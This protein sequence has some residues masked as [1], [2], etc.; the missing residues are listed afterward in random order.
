MNKFLAFLLLLNSVIF[1]GCNSSNAESITK[2]EEIQNK[3]VLSDWS[4]A[5]MDKADLKKRNVK[6]PSTVL[7]AL[8]LNGEYGDD[9]WYGKN[10]NEISGER[11]ETGWVYS[12]TF[13]I[14]DFDAEKNQIIDFEGINYR[15]NIWVNGELVVDT[16]ECIGVFSTFS[17]N[18]SEFTKQGKNDLKVEMYAPRAGDFTMGFVDWA[19]APAD[20][21]MGIWRP[22]TIK[23]VAG[24][25]LKYT[26]VDSDLNIESLDEADVKITTELLNH[27]TEAQSGVV[28]GS[29]GDVTFEKYYELGAGEHKKITIDKS[30]AKG[31]HF[32][33]PQ[34]WWPV[35]MGKP[36]LYELKIQNYTN[37]VASDQ[38]DI[39]FGI[40]KFEDYFTEEG[41]RGYRINGKEVLRKGGGWVDDLLL[42][43]TVEYDRAQLEYAVHSGLN[44]VR[45]EGFWG[46]DQ[47]LYSM[48][49]EMGLLTMVGFSCQWEWHEYIG[50]D[51]FEDCDDCVGGAI[52]KEWEINLVADYFNDMNKWF[53]NHAGLFLWTGGSDRLHV[54][55]LEEKYLKILDEENPN[56]LFCGAAKMHT[57]PITGI[58]GVK[59]YGP[60][61]Y[62]PPSYWYT[63]TVRGGAYGFNTE[64]GPG[65]QPPVLA[66]L[67]KMIPTESLWPIDTVYWNFHSGR[68]AFADMSRYTK[69]LEARYGKISSVEEFAYLSQIQSYELMRPMYESFVLNRPQATGVVQWMLNSAWP[70]TFWQFYDYYLNATG[71]LY[72]ARV[73]NQPILAAYN[74]KD[75]AVY[76][77]NESYAIQ[78]DLT[79]KLRVLDV[80]SNIVSEQEISL[81]VIENELKKI[82][83]PLESDKVQALLFY[84]LTVLNEE[85]KVVSENFYWISSKED[86]MDPVYDNSNWIYT[87]TVQDADLTGLRSLPATEVSL[88]IKTSS[89]GATVTVKNE[90]DKLAFGIELLPYEAGTENLI[91]PI[92]ISDNYFSLVPGEEKIISLDWNVQT[93]K[94]ELD[95]RFNSLNAELKQ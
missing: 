30:D 62:V 24:V 19:P 34:I 26:F 6:V 94:K 80:Q 18:I 59:M 3:I 61:D 66:S 81:T 60:Y 33:D 45:F 38:E 29:I 14:P 78:K 9:I 39:T 55:S 51:D 11:F 47:E 17:Y 73:A 8:V 5:S 82:F 91:A 58:T 52:D 46:K 41:H 37:G 42:N 15:A 7:G 16:T 57:S 2:V 85:G 95:L 31:L 43:N 53:R 65:P 90:G 88:A 74:Y 71:A 25:E 72:G 1:W 50:V 93:A 54:P 12:T 87:P 86:L 49:D 89:D 35:N 84:D 67:K 36:N 27:T 92:L 83:E 70:E 10:L 76:L 22:V 21:N 69:P 63:D 77:A 40:R 68:H 4:L 13:E 28:I 75:G 48:C 44:C 23:Q 32:E 79:V 56:A 64:T 20:K